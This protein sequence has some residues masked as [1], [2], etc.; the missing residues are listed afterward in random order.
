MLIWFFFPAF[1]LFIM[2]KISGS[3]IFS[4]RYICWSYP[5][6]ALVVAGLLKMIDNSVSRLIA[7]L[8]FP[9]V[10]ILSNIF[11]YPTPLVEDWKSATSYINSSDIAENRP[12]LVWPGLIESRNEKW[13]NDH[14]KRDY[15]L[16]PFSYYTL[17]SKVILLPWLPDGTQVRNILSKYSML[18]LVNERHEI[19]LVVRNVIYMLRRKSKKIFPFK[20]CLR[21][22]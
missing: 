16:A 4:N 10:L 3:S 12:I 18:N 17:K 6:I 19:C 8:I 22:G 7:I 9:I 11:Y 5:A 14:E 13:R 21:I 15:L 20:K 1:F 2:S